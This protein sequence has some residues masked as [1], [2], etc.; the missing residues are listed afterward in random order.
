MSNGSRPIL[1][2]ELKER[3]F[4]KLLLVS[5]LLAI[6]LLLGI[7]F[8]LL[9][10]SMLSIRETGVSFLYQSIWDPVRETFGA[11]PFLLGTMITSVL[12]LIISVPF[13][14]A[15]SL[16]LGE[17]LKEGAFR[18]VFNGMLDLLA[19]IPSIIYGFWGLFV[20]VPMVR[21]FENSIGVLAHGVG[22]FSSSIVL[23]LMI[24]PYS[25]SISREV[26][27]LVPQDLKEAALSLGATPW[28]VI[29]KVILPYA[30][31]GMFAGVLMSFGRAI[32]ETMAVTMLIGNSNKIPTSLFSPANTLASVIANEFAEASEALYLSSL[33]E[34]ALILFF[35]TAIFSLLGRYI[36]KKWMPVQ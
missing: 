3:L 31:S 9:M 15:L 20:L 12:A 24:I 4:K 8:T 1:F 23:A 5:G 28:E 7:F 6:G 11:W 27:S 10:E 2:V 26:I 14:F 22:I 21:D 13:S 29:Q 30:K 32:S 36:I 33:V 34:L 19:G 16:F 25:A 17:Y 18:S 35:V